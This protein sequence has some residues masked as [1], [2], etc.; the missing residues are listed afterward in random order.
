MN[1]ICHLKNNWKD[2]SSK[3]GS[4]FNNELEDIAQ[5]DYFVLESR[6]EYFYVK[7]PDGVYLS[8]ITQ[9]EIDIFVMDIDEWRDSQLD[10][11]LDK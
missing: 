11:L 2:L 9:D 6:N 7:S 5:Y 10:K 1:T 3:K 4:V 8:I